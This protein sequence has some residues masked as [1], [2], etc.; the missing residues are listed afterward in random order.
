MPIIEMCKLLH[1]ENGTTCIGRA[2]NMVK[3]GITFDHRDFMC[4][5]C[6]PIYEGS[7][8]NT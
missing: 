3:K 6:L 4:G 2:K 8:A 5:V 1:P 7:H